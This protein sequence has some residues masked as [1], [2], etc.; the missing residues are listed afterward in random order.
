MTT[1]NRG[2][3]PIHSS[4]NVMTRSVFGSLSSSASANNKQPTSPRRKP[5]TVKKQQARSPL[6][7]TTSSKSNANASSLMTQSLY[8]G[9][10]YNF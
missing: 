9:F 3:R 4:S 10:I 2:E 6:S 1:H 8:A 7:S 5:S